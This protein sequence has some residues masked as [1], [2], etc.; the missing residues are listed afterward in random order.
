[1]GVNPNGYVPIFDGGAPRIITGYAKE[2][3]SGGQFVGGST[4]AGVVSSGADS[5]VASDLEFFHTTGSGNFVGIA[6]ADTSSGASMAVA[7]RGTFLLP[8]SGGTNVLA[9]T[10][11][12]C[13]NDS[14]IIYLGSAA[15]TVDGQVPIT[16][17][18]IGRAWT[19]GSH[20]DFIVC[21]IHG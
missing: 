20:G 12:G 10:K 17:S 18:D 13:N 1:M 5:F 2:Y 9:G 14:E 3:I 16:L 7:T 4:A 6:L 21:D 11:V 15:V 19:A 8:V